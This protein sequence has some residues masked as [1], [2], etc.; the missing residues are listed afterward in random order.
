MDTSTS[1][2]AAATTWFINFLPLLLNLVFHNRILF[3]FA[4]LNVFLN[5]HKKFYMNIHKNV[6]IEVHM[7]IH[8]RIP[9]VRKCPAP[10]V[11]RQCT[12]FLHP[13]PYIR[14][15]LHE[16]SIAM[17]FIF[18]MWNPFLVW[19]YVNISGLM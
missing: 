16:M 4:D 11:L 5:V 17:D 14:K 13:L 10:C 3:N 6:H 7:N 12:S 1:P 15:A 8:L 2:A 18:I 9:Q 19:I